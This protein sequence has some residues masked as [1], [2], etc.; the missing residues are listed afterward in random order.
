MLEKAIL[1]EFVFK[2]GVKKKNPRLNAFKILIR[3]ICC[4]KCKDRKELE[5]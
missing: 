3:K 5:V 4:V 1:A 2:G